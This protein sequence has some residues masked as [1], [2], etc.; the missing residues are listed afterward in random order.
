[1]IITNDA[2]LAKK[3]KHITTTGR[4]S[5][6]WEY[7][8]DNVAYNYRLTNVNAAIGYAQM[9]Q[10]ECFIKNKR[11]TA[12]NYKKKFK[13]TG[14]EFFTEPK[15]ARSNYWLNTLILKDKNERNAFLEYTNKNGVM[16]RPAWHLMNKLEM[17]KNCQTGNLDNAEWLADRIVNIPS[18]VIL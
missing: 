4:V 17:Y 16:T 7:I 8:H 15:Y 6:K 1:M 3:A 13:S 12:D 18:S 2:E 10:I 11:G 14:I 9:E 5:H